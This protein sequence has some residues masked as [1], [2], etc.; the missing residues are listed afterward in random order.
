MQKSHQ[1][2]I[3]V[4]VDK[5]KG[6][7]TAF[8]AAEAIREGFSGV[9]PDAEFSMIPMADGGDGSFAILHKSVEGKVIEVQTR[10]ARMR[11]VSAP[12]FLFNEGKSAFIESATV[13]GLA[14][15]DQKDRDPMTATS[16]GLGLMIRRALDEGVDK[17]YIGLGGT[18]TNDVG[19]G[20]MSAL[21]CR[22]LTAAGEEVR[23]GCEGL[24]AIAAIDDSGLDRRF[25]AAKIYAVTDVSNTLLGQEGATFTFALQKGASRRMLPEMEEAVAGFSEVY[26]RKYGKRLDLIQGGGAAGGIGAMILV[27]HRGFRI[28]GWRFF[29][30]LQQLESRIISAD[31][32]IT[33]EGRFDTQSLSGKVIDGVEELCRKHSRPLWVFCGKSDVREEQLVVCPAIEQIFRISDIEPNS[34]LSI[35]YADKLLKELSILAAKTL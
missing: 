1:M 29:A 25:I 18:A 3:C 2:Q 10:D 4:A 5:F 22:Y 32:V 33:G 28:E 35:R 7:L 31:L 14:M 13:C 16:Y 19:T 17:I 26:T 34:S 20:M 8:E 24:S 12:L 6:S 30:D 21:G 15:L 9:L 27:Q 23:P 11:A